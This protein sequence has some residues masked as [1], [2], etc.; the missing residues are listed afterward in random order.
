MRALLI[1]KVK[2]L[3]SISLVECLDTKIGR[4]CIAVCSHLGPLALLYQQFDVSF[5]KSIE[6]GR[7][8]VV[9]EMRVGGKSRD[10]LFNPNHAIA[11]NQVVLGVLAL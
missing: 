8:V 7:K 6:A 1:I 3:F 2:C 9:E 5:S 10:F 4:R 11:S